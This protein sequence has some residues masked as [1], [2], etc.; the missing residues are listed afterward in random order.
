M[1]AKKIVP[2][3]M[4]LVLA[5]MPIVMVNAM[6]EGCENR[7]I[8]TTS[9]TDETSSEKPDILLVNYKYPLPSTYSPD[10]IELANGEKVDSSIYPSLQSMFDDARSRGLNLKV[11]S[12]YRSYE[13]QVN[14]M[15]I[16]IQDYINKGMSE[17]EAIAEAQNWV[18]QPG[19][20]EHET[21]LAVDIGPDK[22]CISSRMLYAWLGNNA[23]NYGFI[24]RYPESKKSITHVEGEH[25][26]FRYVG[27]QAAKDMYNQNLCLEEYLGKA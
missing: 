3:T 21:G 1:N 6:Q 10:L 14:I 17:A 13:D 5:L 9:L 4:C 24:L 12:G 25:W 15:N 2:L 22:G 27:K 16:Y 23:H 20:S 11:N 8:V 7:S 19:F 26:H 18:A